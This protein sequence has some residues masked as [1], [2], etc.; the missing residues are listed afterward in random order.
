[1]QSTTFCALISPGLAHPYDEMCKILHGNFCHLLTRISDRDRIPSFS[2][3]HIPFILSLSRMYWRAPFSEHFPRCSGGV[4]V[5]LPTIHSPIP[6]SFISRNQT[7]QPSHLLRLHPLFCQTSWAIDVGRVP[8]H[9]CPSCFPS[10][11]SSPLLCSLYMAACVGWL[12]FGKFVARE[13]QFD[14][15]NSAGKQRFPRSSISRNS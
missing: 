11:L 9:S 8:I 15:G 3:S 5:P 10:F 14:D 7:S 1:M 4:P 12:L 2:C 6:P 13:G